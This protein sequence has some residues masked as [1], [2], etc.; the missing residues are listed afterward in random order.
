MPANTSRMIGVE[1]G[2]N[3]L[4]MVV[5]SASGNIKKMIVER[6]PED[7][8]REGVPV[9]DIAMTEF[10]KSVMDANNIRKGNCALVLPPKTVIG[11][12]V[13]MPA[14]DEKSM[15]LNL[16]YEFRDFVGKDGAKFE[17][18]YSMIGIKD[19]VMELYAAAVR[20]EVVE[21]YYNIFK[22]AGLTLKIAIPAEMAWLNLISQG[23]NLPN[24]LCLVDVGHNST[25]V[26]IF[27]NG[28]FVMGKDI[29][30][31]GALI[32][33][34]IA[35]DQKVDAY[36]ARTRKEA[37]MNKILSAEFVNDA[38]QALAIEVMKI[39]NYYSYTDTAEGGRLEHLYY[40]GGSSVIEPL[41]T[42]L[43]KATGMTLHHVYRM[44]NMDETVSDMALYCA[45][46]AGAAVQQ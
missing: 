17:Y 26:N 1:I 42:A 18:D 37:N 8:V 13:S 28:N 32:D 39:V 15:L 38:Y 29:E 24:K 36:V 25:R 19:N 9:S 44:V 10:L 12:H 43:L 34:T 5:C 6:M 2:T 20:K 11:H 21:Q 4:K 22:K 16:P 46:A 23:K 7:L 30:M 33:E 41:R 45:L 14:M 3:T 31:A 27:V 35:A 40:C